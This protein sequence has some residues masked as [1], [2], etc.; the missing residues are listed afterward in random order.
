MQAA[1][2]V[3]TLAGAIAHQHFRTALTVEHKA[4]GSEVT[5]A[6]R[7]AEQAARD[8]LEKHFPRDGII[9]E[10]FGDSAPDARRK[11]II[12]PIDGT[13]SFVKGVPLWGTLVA[14][15][16]DD[17]VLAS[18]CDFAAAG[19]HLA[20]GLGCGAWWN[21][22]RARVS[23][24][25]SLARATLLCTDAAFQDRPDRGE[26]WRA[27]SQDT[28]ILRSWGDCFGYL[29]VATGRAELMTDSR[30]NL[31]DAA[32][33]Q[34]PVTEAGGVFTD[35][36]GVGTLRGSGAIATNAALAKTIREQ[37]LDP[38]ASN[39]QATNVTGPDGRP[40]AGR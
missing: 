2:E 37:L 14:V 32:P 7:A 38:P 34:L 24:V 21:G 16:E 35:W 26:R 13:K 29:M 31:W 20:A 18:A 30:L 33:V 25:D 6:D 11:W 36:T 8:W 12:D 17:Q 1:S 15:M 40:E 5:I 27:L 39:P 10:E 4:D 9:G 19:E 23:G 28:T 3:A 22:R